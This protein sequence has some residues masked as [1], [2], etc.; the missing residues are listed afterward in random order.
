MIVLR[1]Q[2]PSGACNTLSRGRNGGSDNMTLSKV[3]NKC[4][5]PKPATLEFFYPSRWADGLTSRC[6]VCT[7]EDVR[8]A[9]ERRKDEVLS[10]KRKWHQDNRE[11][12]TSK[13]REQY[14]AQ[15]DE[16]RAAMRARFAL[17]PLPNRQRVKKW[18]KENPEKVRLNNRA[19]QARRRARKKA[20]GG[21]YTASDVRRQYALQ[22]G[23]CWWCKAELNGIFH[24][25]HHI[26]LAKG[27]TNDANNIVCACPDCNNQKSAKMPWEF[28]GR[29]L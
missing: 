3:C 16:N 8:I 20:A 18:R 22:G 24:A 26:P 12:I 4:G 5:Q 10:Y 19:A 23:K 15:G 14:H 29:L 1:Q 9:T 17:N 6:R 27:G 21:S 7:V 2:W 25:D 28:A 13:K 11:R